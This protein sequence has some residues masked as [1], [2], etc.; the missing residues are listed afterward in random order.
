MTITVTLRTE[1]AADTGTPAALPAPGPTWTELLD[2]VPGEAALWAAQFRGAHV[3]PR[4]TCGEYEYAY[5]F[6]RVHGGWIRI[7][8]HDNV[9]GVA[10]DEVPDDVEV[11]D[12][13]GLGH[14]AHELNAQVD[15]RI[16]D[17]YQAL[18]DLAMWYGP[19]EVTLFRAAVDALHADDPFALDAGLYARLAG[20]DPSEVDVPD[21]DREVE[22]DDEDAHRDR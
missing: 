1:T 11:S 17:E 5:A 22:S 4:G 2:A 12:W 6:D 15:Q 3:A 13:P 7:D 20:L 14:R 18:A 16:D 8:G 19:T 10:A 9:V 21:G